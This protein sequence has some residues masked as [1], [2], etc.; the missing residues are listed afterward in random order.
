MIEYVYDYHEGFHNF[1]LILLTL[2]WHEGGKRNT[3]E[4]HKLCTAFVVGWDFESTFLSNRVQSFSE[5]LFRFYFI[6][7]LG[8]TF[9]SSS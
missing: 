4:E 5:V 2:K 8:L 7:C 9:V 1:T 3:L 6:L